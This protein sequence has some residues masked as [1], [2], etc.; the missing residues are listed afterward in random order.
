[1]DE[2]KSQLESKSHSY[3]S[4]SGSIDIDIFASGI[5]AAEAAL[6]PDVAQI[7]SLI[8]NAKGSVNTIENCVNRIRKLITGRDLLRTH[9]KPLGEIKAN[10]S[11]CEY[12]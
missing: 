12:I 10:Y 2:K 3:F 11:V 1:M 6:L 9:I 8:S 5:T 4:K 7:A